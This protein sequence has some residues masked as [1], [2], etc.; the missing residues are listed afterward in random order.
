MLITGGDGRADW[1]R[2]GQALHRLLTHAAASWVFASLYTQPLEADAI[3][4][5]IRER[6]ALPGAPQ[7]LLQLGLAHTT[8]PTARR[9]PADLIEP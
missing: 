8:H 5:L 4:A 9:S 7:M 1:L 2:A 3:R 6:L